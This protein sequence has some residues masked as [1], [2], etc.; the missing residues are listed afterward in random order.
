MNQRQRKLEVVRECYRKVILDQG[1]AL[2]LRDRLQ[3]ISQLHG[4]NADGSMV[5]LVRVCNC[6]WKNPNHDPHYEILKETEVR[7]IPH[8]DVL[9]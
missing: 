4:R 7:N 3:R 6:C 8:Y 9:S 1:K 5:F 2:K